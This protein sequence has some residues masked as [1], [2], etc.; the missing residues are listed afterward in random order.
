MITLLDEDED[1]E[2]V[3]A[4]EAELDIG[5]GNDDVGDD[6]KEVTLVDEGG[7]GTLSSAKRSSMARSFSSESAVMVASSCSLRPLMMSICFLIC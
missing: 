4:E 6:V 2:E 3:V 5:I 7:R 1:V